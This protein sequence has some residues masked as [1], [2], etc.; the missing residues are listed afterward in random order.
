MEEI[1]TLK[2]LINARHIKQLRFWHQIKSEWEHLQ[3]SADFLQC[4]ESMGVDN[5]SGYSEAR[6]IYR[7][8]FDGG[9]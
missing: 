1:K 8:E 9:L 3:R 6:E 7:N 5:W 4:L 2:Q